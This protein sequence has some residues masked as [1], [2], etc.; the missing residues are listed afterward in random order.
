ME[1]LFVIFLIMIAIGYMVAAM[2][3]TAVCAVLALVVIA[4]GIVVALVASPFVA[5]FKVIKWIRS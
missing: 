1:A 2:V 3:A 4:L 5:I